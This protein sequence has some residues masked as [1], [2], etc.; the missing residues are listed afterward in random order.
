MD[1]YGE[2]WYTVYASSNL[3]KCKGDVMD[4]SEPELYVI[5]GFIVGRNDM[6]VNPFGEI[7]AV[8]LKQGADPIDLRE[9]VSLNDVKRYIP[10]RTE[11]L[12]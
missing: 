5:C 11:P 3:N 2:M 8:R 12:E 10:A 7:I 9:A 4:R 1:I 6:I